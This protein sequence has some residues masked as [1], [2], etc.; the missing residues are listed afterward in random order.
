MDVISVALSNSAG[1]N[2]ATIRFNLITKDLEGGAKK[3]AAKI[4]TLS[5]E[6]APATLTTEEE[7][8]KNPLGFKVLTYRVDDEIRR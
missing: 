4:V 3:S 6:Y 1:A 2:V 8:L 7:R 5:Y